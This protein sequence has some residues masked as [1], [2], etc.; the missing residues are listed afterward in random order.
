MHSLGC[1]LAHVPTSPR[2][3]HIPPHDTPVAST[4]RLLLFPLLTAAV[5]PIPCALVLHLIIHVHELRL[6]DNKEVRRHIA[7]ANSPTRCEKA[8]AFAWVCCFPTVLLETRCE[9]VAACELHITA[10]WRLHEEP[11]GR[12]LKRLIS[13]AT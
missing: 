1:E 12:C 6:Q 11:S 3:A 10:A 8:E 13:T 5:C 2:P 9:G 4:Y 7:A